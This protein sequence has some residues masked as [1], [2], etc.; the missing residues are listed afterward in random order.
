MEDVYSSLSPTQQ[1]WL[2]EQ[3][4][5]HRHIKEFVKNLIVQEFLQQTSRPASKA[6]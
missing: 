2:A 6:A 4:G 3:L 5:P 1:K